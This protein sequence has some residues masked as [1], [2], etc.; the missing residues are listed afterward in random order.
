MGCN[1][2]VK[3]LTVNSWLRLFEENPATLEQVDIINS[4]GGRRP[5]ATYEVN[6]LRAYEL[7]LHRHLDTAAE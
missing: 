7:W 2:M 4:V 3:Q 5:L 1:K 6:C